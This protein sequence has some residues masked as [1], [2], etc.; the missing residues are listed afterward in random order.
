[1]RLSG[2]DSREW[3]LLSRDSQP[4]P[5]RKKAG[6][7]SGAAPKP[8]DRFHAVPSAPAA[9]AV[10][11]NSK[12]PAAMAAAPAGYFPGARSG[13]ASRPAAAPSAAARPAA[14]RPPPAA[15]A[16][17]GCVEDQVGIERVLSFVTSRKT[18]RLIK[19]WSRV[20]SRMNVSVESV[21]QRLLDEYERV[22]A[23]RNRCEWRRRGWRG[24]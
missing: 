24:W 4:A 10:R 1:M 20:N 13:A 19:V 16:G 17:E 2:E 11:A 23:L 12:K 14:A 3:K 5:V 15:T 18:G 6:K 7:A 9:P 22:H 8:T 21:S